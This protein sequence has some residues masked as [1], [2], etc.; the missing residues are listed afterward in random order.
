[1]DN[2]SEFERPLAPQKDSGSIISH[3][4][5]NYKNIIGYAILFFIIVFVVSSLISLLFP[6]A[7]VGMNFYKEIIESAKSGNSEDL[8]NMIL[9]NQ[10]SG[11]GSTAFS[12]LSSL[13]STVILYPLSV[14]IIYMTHKS[15]THQNIEISD[16][17]IG[18]KQNTGN[19]ILYGLVITILAYAGSVFCLLPGLYVFI[20]GFVGLPIVFFGNK[21]VSDGISL[22]F[23]TTNDNFGLVLVVAILGFLISISGYL[24]CCI[25]AIATLP[26]INSVSYS[27]YCALFGTPY[28]VNKS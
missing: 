4:W 21:N 14:G 17:F 24:L 19:L 6:G 11:F 20:A 2:F 25:G 7:Q 16:L 10:N 9:E 22:S 27:L 12:M 3:A 15:N 5:E 18:Y 23:K 13:V 28:E 1:M 8:K 26:F